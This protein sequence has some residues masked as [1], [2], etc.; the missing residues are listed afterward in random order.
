MKTNLY[1]KNYKLFYE[2]NDDY[3]YILIKGDVVYKSKVKFIEFN[4]KENDIDF[5]IKYHVKRWCTNNGFN[6]D[7]VKYFIENIT[8]FQNKIKTP[9][10]F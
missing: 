2:I 4:Y 1:F 3:F 9:M 6:N 10:G 5:L 8:C 7:A